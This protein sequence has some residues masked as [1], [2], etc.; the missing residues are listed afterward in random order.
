[1][2]TI[3]PL[4]RPPAR[5]PLAQVITDLVCLVVVDSIAA[6]ARKESLQELDREQFVIGQAA[7]LKTLAERCVCNARRSVPLA[8]PC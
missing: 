7:M 1:M 4:A 6:L 3:Q 2:L 5:P 8:L